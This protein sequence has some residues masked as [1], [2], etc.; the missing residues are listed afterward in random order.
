MA[1]NIYRWRYTDP[2]TGRNRSMRHRPSQ[3]DTLATLPMPPL[4]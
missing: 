4:A 2:L 3:A 1:D